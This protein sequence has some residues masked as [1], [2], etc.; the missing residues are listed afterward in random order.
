MNSRE[1]FRFAQICLENTGNIFRYSPKLFHMAA[2]PE[3]FS[4]E[5][6][7][8]YVVDLMARGAMTSGVEVIAHGLENIPGEDGILV[9]PNHS[10]RFDP[11]AIWITFPRLL[12][13]VVD[14]EACHRPFIREVVTLIESQRLFKDNM[15]SMLE[16]T[17][18]ITQR[19]KEQANY[20]LFPEGRYSDAPDQVG[21]FM[22]GCFRSPL[23]AHRPVVPVAIVGSEPVFSGKACRPFRVHVHYLKAIMPEQMTGMRTRDL[24]ALVHKNIQDALDLYIGE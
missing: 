17:E 18:E 19:L 4:E 11:L 24:S 10:A 13:V 20:M 23:R 12:G 1:F 9:C 6:K 16:V 22:N 7:Y 8:H 3:K 2:H 15:R 5:E 14:D 21:E